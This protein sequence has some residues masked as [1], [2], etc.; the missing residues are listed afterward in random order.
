MTHIPVTEIA[1]AIN[2]IA[3]V[4]Q[5]LTERFD[6]YDD[7]A[8]I[9]ERIVLFMTFD[10]PPASYFGN[11]LKQWEQ[12]WR[13]TRRDGTRH[14]YQALRQAVS[15]I[16]VRELPGDYRMGSRYTPAAIRSVA[17]AVT[18]GKGTSRLAA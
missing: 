12:A 5:L 8:P 2:R 13:Q 4:V 17:P 14:H 11:G 18:L 10:V 6:I 1:A 16:L 3:D 7:K 9:H 15:D